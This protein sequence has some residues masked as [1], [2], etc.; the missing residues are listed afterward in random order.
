MKTSDFDYHLPAEF[1]AQSPV[2]PRDR[3]R[4]M[5]VRSGGSAGF[6]VEHA[7][8]RDLGQFL[9]PG[10]LLVINETRVMPARFYA[11]KLP[12]GGQVELLLLQRKDD[13]IWE[14]MVGGKGLREGVRLRVQN[15]PGGEVISILEGPRRLIRFEEPIERYFDIA[16]HVPLPPYIHAE[17]ADPGLY[18]TIYAQEM[19]SAAAPTA[20]LHFTERLLD[21]LKVRGIQFAPLVLHVGLDTFAP[22]HSENPLE[23]HIHTEWCRLPESSADLINQT[24]SA[25]KR[26][27]AVG[28]TS[29]RVLESAA[30]Q[31][32]GDLVVAPFEGP[33]GLFILPGYRFRVVDA[34]ITNFH[35]PRSTLLMLVSAFVGRETILQA[36]ELAKNKGYRFFSFGDAMLLFS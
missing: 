33:T 2:E 31:A 32:S 1:I 28:T 22:V 5:V 36:Y 21:D 34:L 14:S 17:L 35:L 30:Q 12:G 18:Q 20:G 19:G 4:L 9:E 25:G 7:V 6:E 24:R 8:F 27:V 13:N 16:G 10:D 3:A 26:V 11:N 15:G 23:H 29:V